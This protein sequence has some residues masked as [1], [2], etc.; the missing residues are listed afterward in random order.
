MMSIINK[1][2]IDERINKKNRQF[3]KYGNGAYG[4]G[5]NCVKVSEHETKI[6][7]LAVKDKVSHIEQKM[8][9]D[10]IKEE[11]GKLMDERLASTSHVLSDVSIPG[12]GLSI[13]SIL[14]GLARYSVSVQ[15]GNRPAMT[16]NGDVSKYVQFISMFR[17]TF[18]N[19]IKDSSSLYNL[20]T[21]H[22]TELAKQAI[23]CPLCL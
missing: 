17:T 22:V 21:Q 18:N 12:Q 4:N 3:S 16:F 20:L 6:L 11:L 13:A 23:V 15:L 10:Y 14:I 8:S 7:K 2:K 1:K 19:V 9:M 5:Q